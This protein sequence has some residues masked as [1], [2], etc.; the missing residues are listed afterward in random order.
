M[1]TVQ[2]RNSLYDFVMQLAQ[3]DHR[4][5]AGA[6]VGS[7]ALDGGDRWSD[8]DLTFSV[9]DE[10][11][12]FDVLG[13]WTTVLVDE[14][15]AAHLFDVQRGSTVFRVFLLPSCLQCDLSFTPK[16]Q[17]GPTGPKFKLLFGEYVEKPFSSPP[18]AM[19][20]FG[21]AVHHVLRARLCIER[22]RYWQAEFWISNARDY[23]LH[24]ACLRR[25]LPAD[26][27]RGFDSLPADVL[28]LFDTS[29]VSAL[30]RV[31]LM[32]ELACVVNGLLSDVSDVHSLADRV[33]LQLAELISDWNGY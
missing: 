3:D 30:N 27:G 10:F 15:T 16:S 24:L 19:E 32:H 14:L 29:F 7:L 13:D 5:V 6:L 28:N 9:E 12:I 31:D 2:D 23:A 25:G 20:L 26:H 18:S 22:K 21:Y 11:S 8:L 4:V 1:F 17:F 33:K